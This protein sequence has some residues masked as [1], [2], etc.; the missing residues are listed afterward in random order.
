ME[1]SYTHEALKLQVHYIACLW[2]TIPITSGKA[3]IVSVTVEAV[4]EV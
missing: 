4:A 2:V 3:Q 1:A